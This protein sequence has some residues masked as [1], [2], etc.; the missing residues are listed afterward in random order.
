MEE[1][2]SILQKVIQGEDDFWV[3]IVNLFQGAIL[4]FLRFVD[5]VFVLF[6]VDGSCH[7][8]IEIPILLVTQDEIDL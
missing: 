8:D 7:L 4:S 3:A 2:A 1:T 5:P 6:P